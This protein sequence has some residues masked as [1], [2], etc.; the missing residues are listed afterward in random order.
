MPVHNGS[1]VM[2]ESES[3]WHARSDARSHTPSAVDSDDEDANTV[4]YQL[5]PD[6]I[7]NG[8][9][10]QDNEV[11][12]SWMGGVQAGEI[13]YAFFQGPPPPQSEA[14]SG[15]SVTTVSSVSTVRELLGA[16]QRHGA[17]MTGP[18]REVRL[19]YNYAGGASEASGSWT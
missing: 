11:I 4:I 16:D 19:D 5:L 17:Y 13:P 10:P 7:A 2:E 14:S 15:M 18:V 8:R 12:A 6:A 9:L 3:S 1:V